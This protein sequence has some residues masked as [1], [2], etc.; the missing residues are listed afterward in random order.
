MTPREAIA[1]KNLEGLLKLVSSLQNM[2]DRP[3]SKLSLPLSDRLPQQVELE[4]N[5]DPSGP[6]V[7]KG[8]IFTTSLGE[9]SNLAML[10]YEPNCTLELNVSYFIDSIEM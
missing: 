6:K 1:S 2:I 8:V 9:A 4:S 3:D 7:R 5:N 10:E